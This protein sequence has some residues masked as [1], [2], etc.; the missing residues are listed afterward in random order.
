MGKDDSITKKE[1]DEYL[2]NAMEYAEGNLSLKNEIIK[3]QN[4]TRYPEQYLPIEKY[5]RS[6]KMKIIITKDILINILHSYLNNEFDEN[7][8]H[9]YGKMLF[10]SKLMVDREY[11]QF[12]DEIS[13]VIMRFEQ[14]DDYGFD[15]KE[16]KR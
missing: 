4:R 9:T 14:I 16:A 13:E 7:D 15:R 10:Y 12:K 11:G 6:K 2:D 5:S 8:L 1:V 3:F